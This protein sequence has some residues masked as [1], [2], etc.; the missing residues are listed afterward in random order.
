MAHNYI[1]TKS[2]KK[3]TFF[4]TKI[5]FTILAPHFVWT[6]WKNS[7]ITLCFCNML[8]ESS[9]HS[10]KIWV[11]GLGWTFGK[12]QVFLKFWDNFLV[13]ENINNKNATYLHWHILVIT[14][15]SSKFT[16][17]YV[18]RL[19]VN[20]CKDIACRCAEMWNLHLLF[21]RIPM[22]CGQEKLV[23]S[24]CNWCADDAT[25]LDKMFSERSSEFLSI[26]LL[27]EWMIDWLIDWLIAWL[28]DWLI[29]C[30]IDWLLIDWFFC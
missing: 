4:P 22:T 13:F 5:N 25:I 28:I 8:Y 23:C 7:R 29:D 14:K 21:L 26:D 24:L 27:L 2:L 11:K 12:H 15:Y 20:L 1:I 3:K 9:Q 18:F 17:Y 30:L 16:M 19:R 6:I 10:L